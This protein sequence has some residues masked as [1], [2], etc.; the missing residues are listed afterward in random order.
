[1]AFLFYFR[2]NNYG[3]WIKSV[4][5]NNQISV[6]QPFRKKVMTIKEMQNTRS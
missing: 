2:L 3:R 1:M 5:Q 4:E 6:E